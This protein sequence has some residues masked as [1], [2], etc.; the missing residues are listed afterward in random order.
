[1]RRDFTPQRQCRSHAVFSHYTDNEKILGFT[2][3]FFVLFQSAR[4]GV[5]A[6]ECPPKS[7]QLVTELP[8][9]RMTRTSIEPPYAF[10]SRPPS[11][12]FFAFDG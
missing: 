9:A 8:G 1:M 12:R 5:S 2:I 6:G 10:F 11:G 3:S 7:W 4:A